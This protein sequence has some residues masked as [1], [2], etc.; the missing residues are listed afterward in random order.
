MEHWS[1]HCI[2]WH[3]LPLSFLGAEPLALEGDEVRHRLDGLEPWLDYLLEL[4][5]SALLLGPV[6]ES[7]SH[8]YDTVDYLRIDRR[9]GADEDFDRLIERCHER[10]IRV[11]LDG[12][13]NHVGRDFPRFQH[14]L[15]DGPSSPDADWFRIYWD[16]SGGA[17]EYDHFEGHRQL[18]T[19]NHDAPQV[20]EFV[21][22]VMCHWL[23]RG[24]DG[25][26]L[27]AAY[28]VPPAF[29]AAVLPRVREQFPEAYFFGEVIHGDYA[30]IVAESGL[31][32]VTEYELWKAI[33]G[34]LNDRNFHELAWTLAR[35]DAFLEHFVPVTFVGNHDVTRIASRLAHAGHVAHAVAILMTVGGLPC[36]YAGDEQGF[37]GVKEDRPGGDDAVRPAF[38]EAPSR[39]S[40]AGAPI[41]E[42]HRRLIGLRRDHA[43]LHRA[44]TTVEQV[45]NEHL[46]YR[47]HHG[48]SWIIVTLSCA[49]EPVTVPISA[50]RTVLAGDAVVQP[51]SVT[52]PPHGW[53]VIGH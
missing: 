49:D 2:A 7:M 52:L 34:S 37:V 28:A 40:P 19:L 8:G 12:V 50:G 43:W 27:D 5:A 10:G 20:V 48:D 36:V 15:A 25:W 41:L 33:W 16:P 6:F 53:A 26:R 22:E 39:L 11:L 21:V 38:P 24:V 13:F 47:S 14:A 44:R 42:L 29:W 17:P 46:V 30:G 9:L 35:H 32:S 3:L 23:A 1:E 51:G 45:S 4:G 31:D 18:V